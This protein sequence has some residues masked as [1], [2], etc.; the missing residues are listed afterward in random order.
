MSKSISFDRAATFYDETR[1][2]DDDSLRTIL[3]LLER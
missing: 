1:V 3:D 2:T